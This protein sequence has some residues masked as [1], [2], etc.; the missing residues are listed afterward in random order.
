MLTSG[1]VVELEEGDA[2]PA[3]SRLLEATALRVNEASLTGES[4]PIT[5]KHDASLARATPL[6]ERLTLVHLGTSVVAGRGVAIVCETGVDTEIGRV[7]T[8]LA[9]VE[10][11]TTPLEARLDALGRRLVSVTLGVAALVTGLGVARG[12]ELRLMIETGV[13]LAIAAVPEEIGRAHV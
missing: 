13:A 3:D 2:V 7:G 5:K 4:L 9:T 11:G 1:D 10:A 6:A 12:E 8:L